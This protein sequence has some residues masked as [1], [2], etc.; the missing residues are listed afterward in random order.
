MAWPCRHSPH[1][2]SSRARSSASS[3]SVKIRSPA[4]LRNASR[5][6]PSSSS[7]TLRSL[8]PLAAGQVGDRQQRPP[9]VGGAVPELAGHLGVRRAQLGE[10]IGGPARRPPPQLL[11]IARA[12]EPPPLDLLPP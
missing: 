12:G 5:M 2:R 7:R 3:S 4:R 10:V 6:S 11:E 8:R 1:G 9:V